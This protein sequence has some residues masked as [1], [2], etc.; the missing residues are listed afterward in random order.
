MKSDKMKF[1]LRIDA[2]LLRKF[3][4][5]ADYNARSANREIEALMRAH[6]EEYEK[7]NGKIEQ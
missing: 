5:V 4:H 1:T 6:V 2:E 3:R 7:K